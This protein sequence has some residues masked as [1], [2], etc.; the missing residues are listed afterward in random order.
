MTDDGSIGPPAGD[1][2]RVRLTAGSTLL[3]IGAVVTAAVLVNLFEAAKRPL[4]WVVAASMVAWLLSW[5]IG[6]FDRWIPRWVSI[7]VAVIAF[8]LLVGGAWVGVSATL[9]SEV[10]KLRTALP[11][12]AVDLETRYEAAADFRLV[13]R[14]QAFVN[15]LDERFGTQAEM[16][17]AAG[18]ASTYVV[19]GVLMLFLVGYGP[20]FVSAGLRQITDPARRAVFAAILDRASRTGRD[21]LLIALA[22]IIVVTA[23]C[24]LVFYLLDLPAPFVL[25]LLVGLTDAIPYMGILL[26]GL[27]PLLAAVTVARL[28][29][30]I[31]LVL[32][33]VGLQAIEALVVRPRVDRHTIRVGPAVILVGAL[34]GFELY[35]FGG[36]IYG[37]AALVFVWAILR[38]MPDRSA[39]AEPADEPMSSVGDP[40]SGAT[41]GHSVTTERSTSTEEGS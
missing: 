35:G 28:S 13:E 3:V 23:M 19:T 40:L 18:L 37:P 14:A 17:Q 9:G 24:S 41:P 11:Q 34:I 22:Q 36:A 6:R 2:L 15:E 26:G 27:A 21:Y 25:G 39:P 33:L 16:A 5:V 29:V 8:V 32:L 4:A 7:L 20:R 38:A 30:Y 1:P 31:V 12:A 10:D